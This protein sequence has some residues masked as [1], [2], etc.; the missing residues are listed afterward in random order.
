MKYYVQGD[1]P[2]HHHKYSKRQ[3]QKKWSQ[4]KTKKEIQTLK[5]NHYQEITHKLKL[6]IDLFDIN[7]P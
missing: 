5:V 3:I 7:P 6:T 1:T 4:H 2:K